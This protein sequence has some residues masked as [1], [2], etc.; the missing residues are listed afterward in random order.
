VKALRQDLD[1]DHGTENP[2]S[3]A[4]RRWGPAWFF[5]ARLSW[6][7]P[8]VAAQIS[9]AVPGGLGR[10][11]PDRGGTPLATDVSRWLRFPSLNAF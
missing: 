3:W 1:A 10:F 4:A 6:C 2:G 8:S 5:T 7:R 9:A 11:N